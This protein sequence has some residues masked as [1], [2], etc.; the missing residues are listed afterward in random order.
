[1]PVVASAQDD[2]G[3]P[4]PSGEDAPAETTPA[5][6][7]AGYQQPQYPEQGTTQ[8]QQGYPQEGYAA[9]AYPTTPYPEPPR[10][11]LPEAPQNL[12]TF[13]PLA[14]LYGLINVEYER[15]LGSAVSFFLGT[16]LL[17]FTPFAIEGLEGVD[18]RHYGGAAGLRFYP[19]GRAPVGF[20]IGPDFRLLYV[21]A[22]DGITKASAIGYG[23]LAMFGQNWNWSGF[24]LSIGAGF[25]WLQ[26]Q[27]EDSTGASVGISGFR[28]DFR[29][30]IG[31]GF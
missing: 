12:F 5:E 22:D 24:I 16:Q 21:E 6:A 29:A 1:M 8:P 19:G 13:N 10:A 30:S 28:F 27:A 20:W 14:L 15:G 25:G 11:P 31:F 9:A 3:A 17:L 23:L 26:A 4:T 2:L 18:F 7:P